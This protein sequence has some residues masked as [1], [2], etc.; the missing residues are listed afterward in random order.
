MQSD[1]VQVLLDTSFPGAICVLDEIGEKA[2]N[3]VP[4]RS[5]RLETT[6][7]RLWH[8]SAWTSLE[9]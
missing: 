5:P 7:K 4:D 9:I 1:S 8:E 2:R 3:H 6:N